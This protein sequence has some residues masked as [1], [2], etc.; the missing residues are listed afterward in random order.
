MI[1]IVMIPELDFL[2]ILGFSIFMY[3][4]FT[5]SKAKILL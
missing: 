4:Q 1:D 3:A 5:H 2:V